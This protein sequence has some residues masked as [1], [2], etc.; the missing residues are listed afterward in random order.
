MKIRIKNQ[1]IIDFPDDKWGLVD[2]FYITVSA[3]KKLIDSKKPREI[4]RF[5]PGKKLTI[6]GQTEAEI[7]EE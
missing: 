3:I 1:I 4:N 7:I 5:H 2:P 6:H